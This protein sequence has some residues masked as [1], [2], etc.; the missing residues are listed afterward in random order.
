VKREVVRKSWPRVKAIFPDGKKLWQ[1]D[2]RRK[3]TSLKRK[4][5]A[6]QAEALKFAADLAAE[7]EESGSEGTTIG[8]ELRAAAMLGHKMLAPFGKTVL[9]ACE[10]YRDYLSDEKV[11]EESALVGTL[12]DEWLADKKNPK[13]KLSP[14]TIKGIRQTANH[15]KKV[16]PATRVK[17]V[18]KAD[19]EKFIFSFRGEYQQ[20]G[21]RN[22]SSQFFNWCIEREYATANPFSSKLLTVT[23]P[24]SDVEIFTADQTQNILELCE[25]E[26]RE[27]LI[28]VSVCFFA[29]LR[30]GEAELLTWENVHLDEKQIH[31]LGRTSKSGVTHNVDIEDNLLGWLKEFRPDNAKGFICPQGATL[32]RRRQALHAALGFKAAGQNPQAQEIVQD[33]MRHSYASHWQAKYANAHKLAEMMANSVEVIREHYKKVVSKAELKAYWSIMPKPLADAQ[34]EK[35]LEEQKLQESFGEDSPI[36]V[37]PEEQEELFQRLTA[38]MH[39]DLV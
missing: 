11:R 12:A 2:P 28:Y 39:K 37:T 19:A 38:E 9:Q 31:V 24:Q 6:T 3:G 15:L 18:S 10:F 35:D 17:S 13:H 16:F 14:S 1:C 27:I 33:I 4:A 25:R 21:T 20:E 34:R 5:F 32:A 8:T 22:R 30:P 29:G 26:H 36:S 23:L 7:Y